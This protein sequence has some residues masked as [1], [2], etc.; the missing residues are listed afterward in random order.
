[1]KKL[2][3]AMLFLFCT[4]QVYA[5]Y[6]DNGNGTVTD[7]TTKLMWQQATAPN[8]MN[9]QDA[10]KYCDELNLAG[11]SDWRLPNIDELKTLV[12]K[13]FSTNIDTNYFKETFASIYWSSSTSSNGTS[14]A[15]GVNFNYGYDYGYAKSYNGYVRAVRAGQ[16]DIGS[17]DNLV[18][19][20]TP[21]NKNVP[22]EAGAGN[23]SVANSGTGTMNWTAAVT[24]GVDWLRITSGVNGINSGVINFT[25]A[26]NP[27]NSER[28]GIITVT[29]TG[30]EGSPK[31]LRVIQAAGSIDQPVV[32]MFNLVV[33]STHGTV[34]RNPNKTAYN[35]G[36]IV[37]LTAIPDGGYKFVGWSGDASGNSLDTTVTMIANKTITANFE[38]MT[39][40][41]T[42]NING[43][44]D[45]SKNPKKTNYNIGEIVTLTAS[46]AS[47]YKFVGWSGDASGNSLDT[48][49]TMTANKRVTAIFEADTPKPPPV[50]S[51][52]QLTGTVNGINMSLSWT[53]PEGATGY[54]LLYAPYTGEAP[55]NVN[56]ATFESADLGAINQLSAPL[57]EGAAYYVAVKAYNQSGNSDLSNIVLIIIENSTTPDPDPQPEPNPE[58]S[59]SIGKAIIIAGGGGTTTLYPYSNALCQQMYRLLKQRG[60]ND[61]DIIYM[62][63]QAPDIDENGYLDDD[64]LDYN[65]FDPKTELQA[66]FSKASSEIGEKGQFVLYVHGHADKN[67]LKITRDYE[68]SA[69]ELNDLLS[70]IPAGVQQIIILDTC[71]SGS[72]LDELAGVE[73]RIVITSSDDNTVS[74]N[75]EVSSFS[76]KFIRSLRLGYTLKEAFEDAEDMIKGNPEIFGE[77]S[78]WLDANGDA[79][80]NSVDSVRVASV[81]IGKEG[82]QAAEPPLIT[83]VHAPIDIPEGKATETLWVETSPSGDDRIK[84][85]KATLMAPDFALTQYA[86][87]DTIFN[88]N[89]VELTYSPTQK[90]YEV[91]YDNFKQQGKWKIAYQVQGSDGEWSDVAFGEVNAGGLNRAIYI[92]VS[93]NQ[94]VY[95][96]SEEVRFDISM[97]GDATVDLYVGILYPQ[98]YY[99]TFA[100]PNTPSLVNELR[101]YQPNITVDGN[102]SVP[103]LP[104]Q[105]TTGWTSGTYSFCALANDPLVADEWYFE[106][107]NFELNLTVNNSVLYYVRI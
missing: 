55:E 21:I 6:I 72:F 19:S 43:K 2:I 12:D 15:W 24:L 56:P 13:N 25:F 22:K 69:S 94:S 71:Y 63:P 88:E 61:T 33:N 107:K 57:F 3:I 105:I 23:F 34:N 54:I 80:Y 14:Y 68:I 29:A 36:E 42:V 70:T 90:R 46:P 77:Q 58:P 35:S 27:N 67:Y 81:Y 50:P 82:V 9:W 20:V 49:V 7:T 79:L 91:R 41:L 87:E 83:K 96:T 4:D 98:G 11:Y 52:P 76:E 86:G 28:T 1:M 93:L 97:S 74:W 40:S 48:T 31:E 53:A 99:Q 38:L 78:P 44:G 10:M 16:S 45:V 30:A 39:Y 8:K 18:I 104:L 75:V 101:K 51:T 17:L 5:A 89:M 84:A 62:N 60:F 102:Y 59:S 85:V 26:A 92:S 32:T 95:K 103:T 106:C 64:L 100:Y 47:G 65:L 66:A 73:N 37:T